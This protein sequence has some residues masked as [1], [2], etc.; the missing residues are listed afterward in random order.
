MISLGVVLD[1]CSY[2]AKENT[3][4]TIFYYGS[5]GIL[6][7]PYSINRVRS[8][9]VPVGNAFNKDRSALFAVTGALNA[10]AETLNPKP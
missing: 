5:G 7:A 6:R 2:K 10:K 8:W 1:F 4:N 3:K 9:K